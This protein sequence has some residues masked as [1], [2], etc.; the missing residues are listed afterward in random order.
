MKKTARVQL[1]YNI[2]TMDCLTNGAR[3]ELVDFVLNDAGHI[4]KL[5]V[6]FDENHQGQKKRE[7]Q[8]SLSSK[9]QGCTAIER[10]MFQYS[11][12]KKNKRVSSTAKVIQFPLMLGF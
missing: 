6:K 7:S 4:D 3:G 8:S 12:G 11:L 10:M 1:T 9:Y 2:D 5:M